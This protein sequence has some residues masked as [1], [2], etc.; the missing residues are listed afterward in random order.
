MLE[1]G[2]GRHCSVL[3]S[4][5]DHNGVTGLPAPFTPCGH[6][7]GHWGGGASLQDV[8]QAEPD[9]LRPILLF[10]E[11]SLGIAAGPGLKEGIQLQ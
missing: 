4:D 11:G 9:L 3:L 2:E 7:L 8:G 5:A 10:C 6:T 1:S